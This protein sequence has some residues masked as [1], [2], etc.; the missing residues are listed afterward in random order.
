MSKKLYIWVLLKF[1]NYAS[2]ERKIEVN[3]QC[4]KSKYQVSE[5]VMKVEK[6]VKVCLHCKSHFNLTNFLTK[7]WLF[8]YP[9]P[10]NIQINFPNIFDMVSTNV[11]KNVGLLNSFDTYPTLAWRAF[12]L[13]Q[14]P[15]LAT[16]V[17][18]AHMWAW[19]WRGVSTAFVQHK[20]SEV[21]ALNAIKA[22][23]TTM[24]RP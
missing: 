20:A 3:F 23:R 4:V 5:Q 10:S 7:F 18:T 17:F 11:S 13:H 21:M 9:V 24:A 16:F 15:G 12:G 2:L 6:V 1:A 8:G 22:L 14:R 19:W